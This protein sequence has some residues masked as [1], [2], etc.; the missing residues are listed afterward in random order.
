MTKKQLIG[1]IP[2]GIAGFL[3]VKG[4][5]NPAD[6]AAAFALFA[7]GM[8][9]ITNV[10]FALFRQSWAILLAAMAGATMPVLIH[11]PVKFW[12]IGLIAYIMVAVA[13]RLCKPLS[14]GVANEA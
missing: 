11:D 1:A 14:V 2:A 4:Y 7:L 10:R 3:M 6:T 9:I 5:A 13:Y 12:L 8:I